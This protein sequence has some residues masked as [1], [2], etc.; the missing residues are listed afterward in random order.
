MARSGQLALLSAAAQMITTRDSAQNSPI[1]HSTAHR[2]RP[3]ARGP[4]TR[5]IGFGQPEYSEETVK[6][7]GPRHL[8]CVPFRAVFRQPPTGGVEGAVGR[9]RT[10]CAGSR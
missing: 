4:D 10:A 2:K 8:G 3:S 1:A 6:P 9:H 7:C 5:G